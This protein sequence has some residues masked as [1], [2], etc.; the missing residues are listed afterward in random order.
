MVVDARLDAT[1]HEP[2]QVFHLEESEDPLENASKNEDNPAAIAC[3]NALADFP[4]N[5]F[6]I[7]I[8]Y[9]NCAWLASTVNAALPVFII[10][11]E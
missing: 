11:K 6:K 5:E 8:C 10:V 3:P 9:P 7:G 1:D 4:L 2:V